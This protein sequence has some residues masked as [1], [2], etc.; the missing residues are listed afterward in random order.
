[1]AE[2]AKQAKADGLKPVKKEVTISKLT[3]IYATAENKKGS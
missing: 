1:L 3:Q 2:Q